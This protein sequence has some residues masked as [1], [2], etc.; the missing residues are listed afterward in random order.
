MLQQIFH[1]S[2]CYIVLAIYTTALVLVDL[3]IVKT[4]WLFDQYL[5]NLSNNVYIYIS[6]CLIIAIIC[7]VY[8]WIISRHLVNT[9]RENR[10]Y[11]THG[12]T[13]HYLFTGM[14]MSIWL[15]N[16]PKYRQL[17][18]KYKLPCHIRTKR[19]RLWNTW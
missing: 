11:Q 6:D 10:V 12:Q 5:S 18:R 16:R 1:P 15:L 4:S 19:G 2:C 14:T 17:K 8:K 9:N 7:S 13:S 3:Y